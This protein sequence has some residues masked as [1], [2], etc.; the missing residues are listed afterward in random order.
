MDNE[1]LQNAQ[2]VMSGLQ[3]LSNTVQAIQDNRISNKN[4][5]IAEDQLNINKDIAEKNFNLQQDQFD[6]Q[7]SLNDT[8]MQRED[9]AYQRQ[10]ADL[11]AAGLSPLMV[12]GGASASPLTSANAPQ[13]DVSQVNTAIQNMY[14]AYNDYFT[15]RQQR[16]NF[17]LQNRVQTAQSYA[18]L[19]ESKLRMEQAKVQKDILDL[20]YTYY[21]NH[22]ERNLG[23]QQILANIV[24]RVLQSPSN[25]VP[26]LINGGRDY[27]QE[28]Y[29]NISGLGKRT[30]NYNNYPT[31][32]QIKKDQEKLLS[33]DEK[34]YHQNL[35]DIKNPDSKDFNSAVEYFWNHYAKYDKAWNSF[36]AFKSKVVND[37]QYRMKLDSIYSYKAPK[38]PW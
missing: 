2:L 5:Q 6:Y 22:P 31:Q 30:A 12:S 24:S 16:Q 15:R 3:Q 35:K 34:N 37:K 7:M 11:K 26:D 4:I 38:S 18:S 17:A 36:D 8:L 14:G 9:N 25:P 13:K 21:K 10:V 20:D 27:A 1:T 23:L 28:F 29:D 33:F 19:A 32:K